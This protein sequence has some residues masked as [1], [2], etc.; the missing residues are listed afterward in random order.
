[1]IWPGLREF[2]GAKSSHHRTALDYEPQFEDQTNLER[3]L[4]MLWTAP[5]LRRLAI[6]GG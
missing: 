4:L 2:D 3:P 5:P 6:L 1:V